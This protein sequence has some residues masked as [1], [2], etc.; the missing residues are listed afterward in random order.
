MTPLSRWIELWMR[1]FGFLLQMKV[2]PV[3]GRGALPAVIL[4]LGCLF[5]PWPLLRGDAL[6]RIEV[7]TSGSGFTQSG[8][9]EPFSLR[10]F[11]Y[12]HDRDGRLLEDYWEL[13]WETVVEDFKEMADLGANV[14]RIH[15]QLGKFMDGPR[16]PNGESLERLQK[17][18][19]LAEATGVY[20]DLTGLGCYHKQDI[21]VWYDALDES[22]RWEEQ[23]YFWETIAS[24]CA[25][26]TSVFCYDLMNEPILAGKGKVETE[27]LA[28]ELGGKYFVQRLTLDLKGRRREQVVDQ[29][30]EKMCRSIRKHD[31]GALITVGVIPWA[32]VF[33]GAKPLFYREKTF[34]HLDFVSVHFYPETEKVE[35]ALTALKVYELGKP[36]IVEECFPLKCSSQEMERFMQ[37]GEAFVDGWISFYW[38]KTISEYKNAV[39]IPDHIV[40]GWL[41]KLHR[42]WQ[43][44]ESASPK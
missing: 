9:T 2:S 31:P 39:T 44:S 37:E 13:E 8:S 40:G 11:N 27:W 21:P 6:P 18:L 28:G 32:H 43:K 34:S 7:S 3:R 4:C 30:V 10:G 38:G 20:L 36:L 24:V 1:C 17:L 23:A 14:V 16:K 33:P 22:E 15:L 26:R 42:K 25:G 29:W 5:D 35:K 19:D 41:E 12:D